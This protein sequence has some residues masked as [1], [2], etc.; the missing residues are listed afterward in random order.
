[1]VKVVL[2]VMEVQV[3][4]EQLQVQV[5]T[6]PEVMVILLVLAHHKETMVGTEPQ[7]VVNYLLAVVAAER[8]LLELQE[9]FQYLDLEEQEE[10]VLQ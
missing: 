4:V 3:V 5:E 8:L 6:L 7:R 9:H 1:V 2:L 10:L